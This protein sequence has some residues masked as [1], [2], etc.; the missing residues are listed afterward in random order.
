LTS[1]ARLVSLAGA[2]AALSLASLPSDL[3]AGAPSTGFWESPPLTQR[4]ESAS[5]VVRRV[6]GRTVVT[7]ISTPAPDCRQLFGIFG[8]P[9]TRLPRLRVESRGHF[10]GMR[11]AQ[12]D[13]IAAIGGRFIGGRPPSATLRARWRSGPCRASARFRLR[14]VRRTAV[15]NGTWTGPA[16]DGAVTLEVVNRGREVYLSGLGPSPWF[17]CADGSAYRIADYPLTTEL[18][19]VRRDGSFT[20]RDAGDDR[21][22]TARGVLREAS[23]SGSLR[24]IEAHAEGRG[25]CDT[26]VI[27]FGTDRAP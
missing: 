19:W 26:G 6:A 22:V 18:A 2:A 25:V 10:R 1:G 8:E 24:V 11:R 7:D 14:P 23:G 20:L 15:R 9:G 3:A 12:T 5:V 17:R 4:G 13:G 27:D 16:A 21:L